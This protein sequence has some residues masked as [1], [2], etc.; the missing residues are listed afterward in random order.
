MGMEVFA[1]KVVDRNGKRVD[2]GDVGRVA[3]H[4]VPVFVGDLEILPPR[5]VHI[6]RDKGTCRFADA[7]NIPMRV[8]VVSVFCSIVLHPDD[9]AGRVVDVVN[10]S[11]D[12]AYAYNPTHV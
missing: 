10:R 5:V 11:Y 6:L 2:V 1:F 4:V 7:H 9:R 12:F 3:G 8:L